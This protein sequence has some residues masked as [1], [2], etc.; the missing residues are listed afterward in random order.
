MAAAAGG[1]STRLL[2][3]AESSG[4]PCRPVSSL[5]SKCQAVPFRIVYVRP[6]I[7]AVRRLANTNERSD[8]GVSSSGFGG[9]WRGNGNDRFVKGGRIVP[10]A[11]FSWVAEP[12]PLTESEFE[13][14]RME[15]L[16]R[17]GDLNSIADFTRFRDNGIHGAELQT[18][19]ITYKTR[20]P[21]SLFRPQKVRMH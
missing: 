11:M 18:A 15:V 5:G 14:A 9:P 16:E 13:D 8:D 4:S 2:C 21:L 20:F 3:K 19:I 6:S 1:I 10:R 17:V 7:S 12:P